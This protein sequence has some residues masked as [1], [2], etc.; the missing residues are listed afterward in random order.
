MGGGRRGGL[1]SVLCVSY[2]WRTERQAPASAALAAV[3]SGELASKSSVGI[4]SNSGTGKPELH[5][6]GEG[7][8]SSAL[9]PARVAGNSGFAPPEPTA[10]ISVET[11]GRMILTYQGVTRTLHRAS[12]GGYDDPI[13]MTEPSTGFQMVA[14]ASGF[15]ARY[16][17]AKLFGSGA[18]RACVSDPPVYATLH[19]R[20]A[21]RPPPF[22]LVNPEIEEL[23]GDSLEGDTEAAE[24]AKPVEEVARPV[25]EAEEA[26]PA[27]AAV[28][29]EPVV[30]PV[31][32]ADTTP[33]PAG[34]A[35]LFEAA[36]AGGAAT[37][38]CTGVAT[39]SADEAGE[40]AEVPS[41][42]AALD[43][44]P[45]NVWS[46]LTPEENAAAGEEN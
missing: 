39:A 25:V 22:E 30:E 3:P 2:V 35:A 33:G 26:A 27:T 34:G 28:V 29:A 1:G 32:A 36:E 37:A 4:G 46:L 16:T 17:V 14:S 23:L 8:P 40:A 42:P 15:G 12:S 38:S 9:E 21:I 11:S 31:V 19:P 7:R 43:R 10:T 13:L 24:A 44:E 20:V 6:T 41:T 18:L 45:V 5:E